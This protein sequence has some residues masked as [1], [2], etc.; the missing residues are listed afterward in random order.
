MPNGIGDGVNLERLGLGRQIGSLG[1]E[2]TPIVVG[3]KH[4]LGADKQNAIRPGKGSLDLGLATAIVPLQFDR[5]AFALGGK[6]PSGGELIR[7][8]FG[9]NRGSFGGNFVGEVQSQ[10][11]KGQ[12]DVMATHIAQ[13]TRAKVP[14][15]A[16]VKRDPRGAVGYH[17][18]RANP[19][20]II[21]CGGN[22]LTLLG[23]NRFATPR[24]GAPNMGFGHIPDGPGLNQFHHPSII[25]RGMNLGTHL[26]NPLV[27]LG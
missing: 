15:T 23:G 1:K 4:S 17:F 2:H 19:K 16:P 20:V 26:G 8:G 9:M 24:L 6:M 13:G 14:I 10:R 25:R 12:V 11:P 21:E 22:G 5:P 7:G 3:L 27:G 18:R